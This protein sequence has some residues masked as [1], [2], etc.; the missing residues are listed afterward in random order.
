[1]NFLVNGEQP[2]AT[3]V[4]WLIGNSYLVET[5]LYLLRLVETMWI[6]IAVSDRKIEETQTGLETF[7]FLSIFL[8][9][10]VL[11]ATF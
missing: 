5:N 1:M 9:F 3:R 11:N 2:Q 4:D 8:V 10:I 6:R 7:V